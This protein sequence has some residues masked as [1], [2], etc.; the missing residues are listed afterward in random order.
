MIDPRKTLLADL[1]EAGIDRLIAR[2]IAI[3][4]GS[5]QAIVDSEYLN[6]LNLNELSKNFVLECVSKFYFGYGS[7]EN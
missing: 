2:Q 1:L 5:S 7:K 6:G 4:A 3:E